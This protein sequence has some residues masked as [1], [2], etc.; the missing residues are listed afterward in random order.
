MLSLDEKILDKNSAVAQRMV[1]YG[2]IN[3]LFILIPNKQKIIFDLSPKIHVQSSG[4]SKFFQF[5]NLINLGRKLMR[6]NDMQEITAQDPFFIGLIGI[7]LKFFTD[8]KLEIQLHG[9]FFSSDY[10]RKS[11]LGNLFRYWLAKLLVIKKAD[12]L[13]VVGERI[14]HS[15]LEL[16]IDK[17]K[18]L[19]K[20]I[21]VDKEKIENYSPKIDLHAKYLGC[22]K[23]FL[24]L[25]R[26]DPV[27]NVSWLVDV[28]VQVVK[29]NTDYLLLIVGDGPEKYNIMTRIEIVGLK[30]SIKMENWTMDPVSYIKTADCLLFPSLSEGYGLVAMEAHAAGT[31][32]IMTDVGAAN[33]ELKSGPKVIIVPVG[34]KDKIEQAILKI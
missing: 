31:S 29:K 10:Y 16:G 32:V 34:D 11:G 5:F 25:G 27:K 17:S 30:D 12:I 15:L 2:Q 24:F 20:P 33:Y 7:I 6:N 4:G 21:F 8:K 3:E 9:D 26:L 13:R 22:K 28:F 23:I 19:I 14:E 18:I 1:G